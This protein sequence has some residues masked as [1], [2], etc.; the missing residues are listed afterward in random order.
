M[1]LFCSLPRSEHYGRIAAEP[2]KTKEQLKEYLSTLTSFPSY[3]ELVEQG[4]GN[5]IS[6]ADH[7]RLVASTVSATP[8]PSPVPDASSAADESSDDDSLVYG[9]PLGTPTPAPM[10]A[11][12][13]APAPAPPINV[14]SAK[15][16]LRDEKV[17]V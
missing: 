12:T 14:L 9:D 15:I 2:P 3:A 13:P 5:V 1:K 4:F 6:E 10:P 17:F 11:P 7:D 16:Y 8:P